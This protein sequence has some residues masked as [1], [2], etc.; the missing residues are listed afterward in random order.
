MGLG[1]VVCSNA[2]V[3]GAPWSWWIMTQVISQEIVKGKQNKTK[4]MM[5]KLNKM[6]K[7]VEDA[8][9]NNQCDPNH[10]YISQCSS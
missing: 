8:N 6:T 2:S 4:K 10:L 1:L 3:F 7:G 9:S 5:T